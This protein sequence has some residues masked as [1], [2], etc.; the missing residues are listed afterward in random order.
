MLAHCASLSL[1]HY[2][3][4]LLPLYVVCMWCLSIQLVTSFQSHDSL[5]M[6]YHTM[7]V[8]ADLA[9]YNGSI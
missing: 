2:L 7:T 8:K 5:S 1:S 9:K 6:Y 3:D 4:T